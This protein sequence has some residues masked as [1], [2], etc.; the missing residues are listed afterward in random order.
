MSKYHPTDVRYKGPPTAYV[1]TKDRPA[2]LEAIQDIIALF[3]HA[4]TESARPVPKHA[5]RRVAPIAA[6]P[7]L[8]NSRTTWARKS[9]TPRV[10][11]R[12]ILTRRTRFLATW[13]STAKLRRIVFWTAFVAV[14]IPWRS[15]LM[16]FF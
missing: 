12:R 2:T 13:S 14:L 7:K 11:P 9:W 6:K 4:G 15:V 3:P 16:L 5:L 8:R 10:N 1:G